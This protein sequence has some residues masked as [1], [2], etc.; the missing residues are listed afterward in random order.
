[1]KNIALLPECDKTVGGDK[2]DF[3]GDASSVAASLATI[4]IL[5]DS[6]VSTKDAVF[7]TVGI[8]YFFYASFL[9]DTEYMRMKLKIIAQEIID[10][11]HLQDL[12]ENGWVYMKFLKG[13][14]GLK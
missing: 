1:M 8:K 7:T 6:V 9:P 10:Q 5:L 2:L 13:M 14:L 4:K 12:Q 11:Y 3:C